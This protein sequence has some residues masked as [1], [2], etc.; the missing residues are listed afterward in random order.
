MSWPR[1]LRDEK[2]PTAFLHLAQ[3]CSFLKLYFPFCQL[4]VTYAE[5]FIQRRD[6]SNIRLNKFSCRNV[7]ILSG[8]QLTETTR[9]ASDCW[10][11]LSKN[12]CLGVM[13]ACVYFL[14]HRCK[15]LG[16]FLCKRDRGWWVNFSL[17]SCR[18]ERVSSAGRSLILVGA[19]YR[20]V[21]SLW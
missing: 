14:L 3:K 2:S 10:C 17:I 12:S 20:A 6:I 4:F 16:N 11:I 19:V 9:N 8:K 7:R 18:F 21:T 1:N 5:Y 13:H 15:L